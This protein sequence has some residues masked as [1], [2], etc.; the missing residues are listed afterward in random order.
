MKPHSTAPR[1]LTL[2]FWCFFHAKVP[3]SS[4]GWG[5]TQRKAMRCCSMQSGARHRHPQAAD[6]HWGPSRAPTPG[7]SLV[8]LLPSQGSCADLLSPGGFDCPFPPGRK[9]GP[10]GVKG[11]VLPDNK[12]TPQAA[13]DSLGRVSRW[14]VRLCTP[15]LHQNR[16]ICGQTVTGKSIL[17]G[18]LSETLFPPSLSFP[19]TF[20][21]ML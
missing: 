16:R 1:Q 11:V 5:K 12:Q 21:V 6:P 15:R 9:P 2:S 4:F 14:Q 18:L 19:S 10:C 20:C 3:A 17:P 8:T 7:L 13:G